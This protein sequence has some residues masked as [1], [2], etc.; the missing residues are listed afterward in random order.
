MAINK[1]TGGESGLIPQDRN[2]RRRFAARPAAQQKTKDAR[3]YRPGKEYR[4]VWKG[5]QATILKMG[6]QKATTSTNENQ[7]SF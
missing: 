5:S 1:V 4:R 7:K 2:R 6:K 3:S